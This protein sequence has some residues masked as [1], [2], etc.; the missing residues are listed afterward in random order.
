MQ[1]I[2][3]SS[4]PKEVFTLKGYKTQREKG[5]IWLPECSPCLRMFCKAFFIRVINPNPLLLHVCRTSLL[6]TVG[7]REIALIN[8]QFLL[9]QQH[10]LPFLTLFIIY[11]KCELSANSFSLE[12]SK[13]CTWIEIYRIK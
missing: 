12:K 2:S 1:Q 3:L 5:K 13:I 10:F 9:F 11:I 4:K 6:K 8:L 7:N